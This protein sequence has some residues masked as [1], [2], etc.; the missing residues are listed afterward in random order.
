MRL[1]TRVEDRGAAI[2]KLKVSQL[3]GSQLILFPHAPRGRSGWSGGKA[4]SSRAVLPPL[5]REGTFN[6]RG[7]CKVL[8]RQDL[9]LVI[10]S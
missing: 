4:G 2:T 1:I 6:S 3:S 10:F 5:A 7:I 8:L 9:V